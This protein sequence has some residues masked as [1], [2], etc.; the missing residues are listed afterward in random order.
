M[1]LTGDDKS[2]LKKVA[3]QRYNVIYIVHVHVSY[4]STSSHTAFT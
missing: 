3:I 4:V 2:G 1:V